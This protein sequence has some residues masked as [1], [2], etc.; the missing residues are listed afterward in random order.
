MKRKRV[1]FDCRNLSFPGSGL[2]AYC[3]GIVENLVDYANDFDFIFLVNEREAIDRLNLPFDYSVMKAGIKKS[4]MFLRDINEQILIPIRLTFKHIDVFHGFDYYVPYVKTKYKKVSTIHDCAAFRD[5]VSGS[6]RSKYRRLLQR[7]AAKASDKIVT[8]SK[9]AQKEIIDVHHVP[10]CKVEFAYNGIKN[11]FYEPVNDS[12]EKETKRKI[13]AIGKYLLYYGGYR[14]NKNVGEL[15]DAF[16]KTEG[17]SL[18]LTGSSSEIT[19]LLNESGVQDD[20]IINWGYA[21]DDEIKCLLDNCISFVTPTTYEGFGLPVAE[22]LSRG[23]RVIC[24]NIEVLR[25]VGGEDAHYFN[26]TLELSNLINSI[27][28]FPKPNRR[29]YSYKEAV[30]LYTRIYNE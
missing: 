6:I 22:A 25:E 2:C 24:N 9:F 5:Q 11:T 16:E 18:I 30:K 20:R 12:I 29:I 28:S 19:N 3:E 26:N 13:S 4:N 14:K 17:Y 7:M 23:A 15:L 10:E 27:E 1:L 8:I 21:S